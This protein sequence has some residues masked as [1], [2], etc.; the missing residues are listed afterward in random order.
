MLLERLD[1]YLEEDQMELESSWTQLQE[2][3]ARVE[4]QSREMLSLVT[5]ARKDPG[6]VS[7]QQL[8]AVASSASYGLPG[9]GPLVRLAD[10]PSWPQD[11][12]FLRL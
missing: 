3:R 10:E 4:A 8:R 1:A 5:K 7:P 9:Q 11:G 12:T 6:L 2:D